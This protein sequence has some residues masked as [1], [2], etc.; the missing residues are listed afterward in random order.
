M[1]L[2]NYLCIIYFILLCFL[3]SCL[4][5]GDTNNIYVVDAEIYTFTIQN[6]SISAI[7][8]TD[9]VKFSIDQLNNVI[10]NKDSIRYGVELTEKLVVTFSGPTWVLNI[11]NLAEGDSTWVSSGDSIDFSRQPVVLR[12]YAADGYTNKTYNVYINIHQVD[13]DSIAYE[14]IAS[15][16]AILEQEAGVYIFNDVFYTYS[17]TG[18]GIQLYTSTDAVTRIIENLSGLPLEADI[19]SIRQ[20]NNGYFSYYASTPGGQWYGS[21]DGIDWSEGNF[22][23]PIITFLGVINEGKLQ[24]ETLACIVKKGDELVFASTSDLKAWSFGNTV[25]EEFPISDYSSISYGSMYQERVTLVGGLSKEGTILNTVWSTTNGLYW[26]RLSGG[27]SIGALPFLEGSNAFLYDNKLFLFNGKYDNNTFNTTV[28]QSIDGGI[29]WQTTTD[30]YK[31]P[32]SYTSRY[33]ASTVVDK[34][35]FIYTFGG[36]HFSYIND[37][38]RG[39]LNKLAVE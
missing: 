27:E 24:K 37:I 33:N 13:P 23:Y 2:K 9:S 32:G 38:W 29:T 26:A 15:D 6:D 16:V 7:S 14:K 18:S 10:Y 17:K 25:P 12:T 8:S 4:G 1:R 22:D 20:F 21:I 5:D 34:K 19:K 36:I 3:T 11:T 30:K 35:N 39:R 31:M 28:Y